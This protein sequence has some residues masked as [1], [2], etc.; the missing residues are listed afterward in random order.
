MTIKGSSL[1]EAI[2]VPTS[3]FP[4]LRPFEF[5][6]SDLFFGRDGQVERLIAKL[7]DTRFLAVVGTSGSGKS[8]LVKAG[9]LPA[10]VGGMMKTAGAK[11]RFV[12]MRPGNDPIGGLARALNEPEVF[13]SDDPEN[14]AIQVAVAEATLRRGSRGL[15]EVVRQNALADDENLLVVIDQFEELFRFAREASRKSK[16][17]SDRYQNAAAAFVKLLLKAS[18]QRETNIFVVLTMRSDFL[19]DCAQFWDL[20]EA[21]N[22]SQYLIPRLTRD[23]LREVITG[24]V[25]LGG[26]EITSRLV[27]QLLNDI[28]DNQDQLP[29]L[30]HLLMRVWDEWK[31]KRLELEVKEGN[32]TVRRPHEEVHNGPA[33]DLCCY[34]AV[35][36]MAGALSRH[37]DEAYEELSKSRQELTEWVFKCL[38]EKGPDNREVRRP[39]NVSEI[40]AVTEASESEVIAVIEAFRKPGRSFLMPPA[41][42]ILGSESLIDISHESLI[43]NWKGKSEE[44]DDWRLFEWV[45]DEARCARSYRRLA[46]TA[47]LYRA[48]EAAFWRDP[49]LQIALDWRKRVG[50]NAAWA[51]RY[52]PDF[53]LAMEFL[54]DSADARDK[55][56]ADRETQRKRAIKR[57]RLTAIVFAGLFLASVVALVVAIQ[58]TTRAHGL[59]EQIRAS[60]EGSKNK[61]VEAEKSHAAQLLAQEKAQAIEALNAQEHVARTNAEAAQKAALVLKAEAEKQRDDANKQRKLADSEKRRAED[62]KQ[63]ADIAKAEALKERDEAK[64]QRSIADNEK[65]RAEEEKSKAD[66]AASDALRERDE[67]NRQRE[68]ADNERKEAIKQK[69]IAEAKTREAEQQAEKLKNQVEQT[70]LRDKAISELANKGNVEPQPGN[71]IDV[72]RHD[73]SLNWFQ[74]KQS[75]ISFAFMKATQGDALVDSMYQYH[76]T[77]AAGVGILTGAYHMLVP[78]TDPKRQAEFFLDHVGKTDLRPVLD[79]EPMPGSPWDNTLEDSMRIWLEAVQKKMGCKPIIFTGASFARALIRSQE[80]G[81]YPLWIAQYTPKANPD[82][83]RPWTNWTLWQYTD[84]GTR[85]GTFIGD[86]S[87]LSGSLDDLRCRSTP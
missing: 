16:D 65:K 42:V 3:P 25:V 21:I 39:L 84:H 10:M 81:T 67:A 61:A 53:A 18:G 79:V 13:G 80:F 68:I 82:V 35:G 38:T 44:E 27:T 51:Q 24:P 14:A 85:G 64:R 77:A 71:V 8:S 43:R 50:P 78:H 48:G 41:D 55:E 75:G 57:T 63:Q 4:G 49:D 5:N 72:S 86:L 69:G 31:E 1:L 19:G 34:E 15:I 73:G 22:K 87:R 45:E 23:Q 60:A 17:E 58:Q 52:H 28:G 70:V 47:V 12:V 56:N 2:R 32:T 62:E 20:P 83:P 30:Q 59:A 66:A 37:A 6:E 11:W 76:Q 40:C 9:L 29:V 54:N 33:I 7:A 74:L 46:E 26:G 36:G